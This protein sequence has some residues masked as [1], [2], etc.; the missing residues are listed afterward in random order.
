MSSIILIESVPDFWLSKT[1][2]KPIILKHGL[3]EYHNANDNASFVT[4]GAKIGRLFTSESVIK[5]CWEIVTWDIL[6]QIE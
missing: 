1:S 6:L 2:F 5:A 3:E 4:F